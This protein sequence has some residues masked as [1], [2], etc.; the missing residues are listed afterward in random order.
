MIYVI[1]GELEIPRLNL[2]GK[3]L[4]KTIL[5]R[6]LDYFFISN[7]LQEFVKHADIF[8]SPTSDH[9]P[10]LVSLMES[11]IPERGRGLWKFN[12]SLLHNAKFIE[13]MKNYIT[14]SL[15]NFDTEKMRKE[16]IRWDRLKYEKREFS[17]NFPK[18]VSPE[19]NKERKVLEKRGKDF[20]CEI[21]NLDEKHK[22]LTWQNKLEAIYDNI[23]NKI[24]IRSGLTGLNM[25]KNL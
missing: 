16:Q 25:T 17:T 22:Y 19:S 13:E 11:V 24:K 20:E 5:Q 1:Y 6:C 8:V 18:Q 23:D 2:K 9:S 3:L 15:S 7:I 14:A 21:Q 4:D 10:I 12:C